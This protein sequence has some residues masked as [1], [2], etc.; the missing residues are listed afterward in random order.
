MRKSFFVALAIMFFVFGCA[1]V[2]VKAPKDP[3]K[4]DISM[5][6]DVYQHV[7]KEIDDIE[8]MVSGGETTT[9][10]QSFDLFGTECAYAQEGYGPEVSEAVARRKARYAEITRLESNGTLGENKDGLVEVRSADGAGT[11][12]FELVSGENGDRMAIYR[13]IARKNAATVREIQVIYA[14]RL[15]KDAP[16]GTPIEVVDETTGK[17]NWQTK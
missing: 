16:A 4:V 5:R 11:A 1:S 12:T 17:S 15:Q 10:L 2:Q 9:G 6:L 8:N 14:K 13:S 3:I 7:A